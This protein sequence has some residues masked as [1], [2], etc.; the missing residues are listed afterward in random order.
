MLMRNQRTDLRIYRDVVRDEHVPRESHTGLSP[1]AV[2]GD[3]WAAQFALGL[4]LR[5]VWRTWHDNPGVDGVASRLWLATTDG[6]SWAAV[7]FDGHTDERFTVWEHGP[8]GLWREVEAAY[9]W[10]RHVGSPGPERFG[11]TVA[12]DGKHTAWLDSLDHPVPSLD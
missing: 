11:V 12:P 4:Q 6:T 2:T 5:D 9:E 8:R 10:W 1:W 3:D 7:D